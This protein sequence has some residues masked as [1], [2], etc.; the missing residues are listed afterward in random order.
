V[1]LFRLSVQSNGFGAEVNYDVAKDYCDGIEGLEKIDTFRV[2]K[3]VCAEVYA[4]E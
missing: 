3:R 4:R 1:Q 2:L